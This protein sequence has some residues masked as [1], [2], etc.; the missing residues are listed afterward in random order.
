MLRPGD[1]SNAIEFLGP[2]FFTKYLYFAGGGDPDHPCCILDTRVATT[3]H[4]AG[5]SSL[6]TK[7]S[8]LASAYQR[9]NDLL[10]D[11]KTRTGAPRRDVI[12]RWLFD[13]A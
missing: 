11:W 1:R 10:A 12:E 2:A 9:Y 8:W 4:R 13:P 7:G 5:W 6:P 3:L